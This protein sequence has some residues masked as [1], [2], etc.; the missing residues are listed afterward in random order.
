MAK[1]CWYCANIAKCKYASG[2]ITRCNLF[3]PYLSVK[4]F[5]AEMGFSVRTFSRRTQN[6][7]SL[8]GIRKDAREKG[9]IIIKDWYDQ[10]RKFRWVIY[11]V[12]MK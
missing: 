8:A 6:N 5:C 1:Y 12:K 4:E 3:N 2:K 11:K 7:K 10:K 9:I